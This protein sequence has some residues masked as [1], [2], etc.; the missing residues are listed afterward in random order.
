M[1][2]DILLINNMADKKTLFEMNQEIT[3]KLQKISKVNE[4]ILTLNNG[5]QAVQK[6]KTNNKY[7]ENMINE[8]Y[9]N[10]DK[11]STEIYGNKIIKNPV[12]IKYVNDNLSKRTK[13]NTFKRENTNMNEE[14]VRFASNKRKGKKYI[15]GNNWRFYNVKRSSKCYTDLENFVSNSSKYRDQFVEKGNE[16]KN[17]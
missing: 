2:F 17:R 7:K 16:I 5:K 11:S 8:T 13:S 12:S 9:T 1:F 4:I 6:E 14:L 3:E 10:M 15:S